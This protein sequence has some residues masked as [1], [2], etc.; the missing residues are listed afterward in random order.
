ME[1]LSV[2][3]LVYPL[4]FGEERRESKCETQGGQP[5][6][7]HTGNIAASCR[8]N[9]VVDTQ[10]NNAQCHYPNSNANSDEEYGLHRFDNS[11]LSVR[12][13][14]DSMKHGS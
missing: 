5:R 1:V 8:R 6:N 11:K 10:W 14:L 13:D 2:E 3:Q 9:T 4:Q 7:R 12:V